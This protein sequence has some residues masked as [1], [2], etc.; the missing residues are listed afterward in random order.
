VEW[1]EVTLSLTAEA[2]DALTVYLPELGIPGAEWVDPEVT[3]RARNRGGWEYSDLNDSGPGDGLVRVRFYISPDADLSEIMEQVMQFLN[4]LAQAGM[5]T[6]PRELHIRGVRE[7][8]WAHAWK[9]YYH[10]VTIGD[11][12]LICPSWEKVPVTDGRLIISLDPGMAFGTGTHPTTQMC[13]EA[14]EQV[15]RPGDSV[16]DIGT[17]SGILAIGSILLGADAVT[18]VDID[19]VAVRTANENALINQVSDRI[20]L[21][22]GECRDLVGQVDVIVANIVADI[23]IQIA[24]C[25]AERLK[26]QGT[27]IVSGIIAPRE[28]DVTTALTRS[29]LGKIKIMRQ[30]DW[31]CMVA[32]KEELP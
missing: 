4:E 30:N 32:T 20:H 11:R 21:M 10:P 19:P 12:F 7:E 14:L 8:D 28:P 1:R 25:M 23:I 18:G 24:P 31:V 27:L 6:G 26:S 29:G 5:M 2:A 22:T 13:L 16:M 9:A 17:G 3:R 15:V